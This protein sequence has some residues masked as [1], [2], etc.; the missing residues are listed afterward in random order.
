MSQQTS[1]KTLVAT[2]ITSLV[3]LRSYSVVEKEK[4]GLG[5]LQ[6][7]VILNKENGIAC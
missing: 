5:T 3:C 4:C 7:T 1:T 2:K 6:W